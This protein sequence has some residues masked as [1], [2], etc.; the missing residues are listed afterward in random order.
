M[1]KIGNS[2]YVETG[3]RGSNN[4][5]VVTSD[6]I[7]M[8][9]TPQVPANALKWRDE[10]ARHGSI[11]YIIYTE[12]HYDHFAGGYFFTGTVVAHEGAGKPIQDFS[13]EQLKERLKPIAP[14]GL[15]LPEGFAFRPPAVTFSQRLTLHVGKH[16]FHLINFPGH[17][18]YQLAVYIPEERVVFTSDNV[19]V[20][21]HGFL[22]E[23]F[24]Y[25][26]LDSLKRME[27]LDADFFVPGHGAVSD[28]SC[29]REMSVFIQAWID[30]VR[31]AIKQGM[32]LEEARAKI[33]LLDRYP[34]PAGSEQ[35]GKMLQKMNVTRLYE[36]LKK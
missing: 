5:F 36:V 34:M 8:I 22:H 12:P 29:L 13:V 1:Q 4:G 7:V 16:T 11:R 2:V 10:I 24:P 30:A 21:G 20:K 23:S 3:F 27:E 26:W 17:T 28:K 6:G 9:D 35:M 32:S 14:Q 15:S 25:A 33:S 31:S 19:I 18:P